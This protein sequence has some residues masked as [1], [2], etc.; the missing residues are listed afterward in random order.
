MKI[1]LIDDHRL[2]L[3]GVRVILSAL[4]PDAEVRAFSNCRAALAELDK[5]MRCNLILVDLH[6]PGLDGLGFL[7]ALAQRNIR[8][9]SVVLSASTDESVVQQ[10]LNLGARGFVP[11]YYSAHE[12]SAAIQTVISGKIY[13]PLEF[14][15]IYPLTAQALGDNELEGLDEAA[16]S[17]KIM[18]QIQGRRLDILKL[19]VAGHTNKNIA[20]IL[21]I[22]E[23]TVKS[24][25]TSLFKVMQVNNRTACVQRAQKLGLIS[26]HERSTPDTDTTQAR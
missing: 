14:A 7:Q 16:S 20:Q 21:N 10:A 22:S 3:D 23:S 5:G 26:I 11:K 6:L 25:I 19:I 18:Q 13:L 15:S 24:H 1:L 17:S 4:Q 9:P 2:F 12:L 8:V